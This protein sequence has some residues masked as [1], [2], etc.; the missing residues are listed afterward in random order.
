MSIG[1]HLNKSAHQLRVELRKARIDNG[2]LQRKLDAA[3]AKIARF[4]AS[5]ALSA[6]LAADAEDT[7]P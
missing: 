4:E 3:N 2:I 1:E 7:C 6:E 5:R